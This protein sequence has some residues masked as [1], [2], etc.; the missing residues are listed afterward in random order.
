MNTPKKPIPDEFKGGRHLNAITKNKNIKV[1]EKSILY[2]L[3]NLCDLGEKATFREWIWRKKED[4]INYL[5]FSHNVL[6]KWL[7]L[8]I[9]K[10]YLLE[11]VG[12]KNGRQSANEYQL[13][14]KIFDEYLKNLAPPDLVPLAPPDLVPIYNAAEHNDIKHN[15]TTFV[16]PTDDSDHN[17]RARMIQEI[18]ILQGYP[19]EPKPC[20][21]RIDKPKKVLTDDQKK[22]IALCLQIFE[23]ENGNR[24]PIY[25]WMDKIL[26]KYGE[27]AINYLEPLIEYADKTKKYKPTVSNRKKIESQIENFISSFQAH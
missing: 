14:S 4:W 7:K 3:T 16:N 9:K 6:D 22:S 24:T 25:R 26:S 2:D 12:Y 18:E 23:L 20:N 17:A 5:G 21:E 8:L 13:T 19:D 10:G 1:F 11:R 15:L 27:K